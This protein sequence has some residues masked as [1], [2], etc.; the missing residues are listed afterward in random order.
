VK[1]K[2]GSVRKEEDKELEE[3]EEGEEELLVI[4]QPVNKHSTYFGTR[5]FIEK[6]K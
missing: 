6:S 4:A 3:G 1:K 2:K 5:S